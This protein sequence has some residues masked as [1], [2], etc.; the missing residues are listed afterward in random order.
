MNSFLKPA[1]S[2][3][4]VHSNVSSSLNVICEN[5]LAALISPIS[6]LY[7]IESE[8]NCPLN[9]FT[10]LSTASVWYCCILKLNFILQHLSNRLWTICHKYLF[11]VSCHAI[12]RHT[13]ISKYSI[14]W[15]HFRHCFHCFICNIIIKTCY[16]K[17][18]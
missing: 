17:A 6:L 9:T 4:L 7:V 11:K 1:S 16:Q 18:F 10:I 5:S 8:Y 14:I 13:A 15:L 3:S 12:A 2:I